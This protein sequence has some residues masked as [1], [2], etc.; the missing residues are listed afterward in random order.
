[1]TQRLHV[2]IENSQNRTAAV[3][4]E[5]KIYQILIKLV[6]IRFILLKIK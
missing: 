1:M 5:L 4:K 6:V 3:E 2:I